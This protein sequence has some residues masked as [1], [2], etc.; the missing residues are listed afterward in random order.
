MDFI[1]SIRFLGGYFGSRLMA[2]IRE[3]KG[4]TYNIF[5]TIDSLHYD[6]CFYIGTEV[7]NDFVEPTI[8]EIYHEM[9][10]LR[11]K[12]VEPGELKMLQNYLLGSLLSMVDGPF[13]VASIV[14][15]IVTE[16]LNAKDFDD[17]VKSMRKY[18]CGGL[19]KS[20]TAIFARGRNVGSGCWSSLK[21]RLIFNSNFKRK[22]SPLNHNVLNHWI[23]E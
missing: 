19:T 4:Y 20:G 8:K 11:E 9:A 13:N 22:D 15:T 10:V 2:N 18:H 16:N 3:E 17:L 12:L 6:S 23:P 7:G 5:S 1:Y 14:R 21:G